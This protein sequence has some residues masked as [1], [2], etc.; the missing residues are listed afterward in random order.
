VRPSLAVRGQ[1]EFDRQVEQ[2]FTVGL[3]SAD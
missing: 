3:T 1:H 2:R